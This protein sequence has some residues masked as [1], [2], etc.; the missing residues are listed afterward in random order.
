MAILNPPSLPSKVHL[1][2]PYDVTAIF[3]VSNQDVF[4]ITQYLEGYTN[5]EHLLLVGILTEIVSIILVKLKSFLD[6]L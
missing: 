5:L 6:F 1:D 3:L 2:Q 4:I